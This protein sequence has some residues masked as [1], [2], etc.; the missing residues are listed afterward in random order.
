V[1]KFIDAGMGRSM[2]FYGPPGSGKSCMS[3]SIMKEFNFR[4]LVFSASYDLNKMNTLEHIVELFG[5][6][7]LIIDDLDQLGDTGKLLDL[8]ELLN[9]K[10]KLVIG[11]ANSLEPFHPAVLRPGRFDEVVLVDELDE[12]YIAEVLGKLSKTYLPLVKHWPIAY[13][14]E[15]CKRS[16]FD[17]GAKL[18][19]HYEE[20]NERVL[21][22]LAVLRG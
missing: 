17:K 5:V 18:K 3:H 19:K 14:N 8:L 6:E 13:I 11:I 12:E 21:D 15:L 2:L 7:A 4:T 22:Q 10:L 20:L 1:K 9:R 16:Q